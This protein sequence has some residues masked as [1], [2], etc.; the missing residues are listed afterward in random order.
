MPFSVHDS[1]RIRGSRR[2]VLECTRRR[3][4]NNEPGQWRGRCVSA[5]HADDFQVVDATARCTTA[6]GEVKKVNHGA[7][8]V[9]SHLLALREEKQGERTRI[10][11]TSMLLTGGTRGSRDCPR[12]KHRR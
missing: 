3:E 2:L 8:I 4:T 6:A 10:F 11:A 7:L 1:P 5:H 12:K 9:K